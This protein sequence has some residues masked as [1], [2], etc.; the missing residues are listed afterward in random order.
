MPVGAVWGLRCGSAIA[1]RPAAPCFG[2]LGPRE[3]LTPEV[4]RACAVPRIAHLGFSLP[5]AVC[6]CVSLLLREIGAVDAAFALAPHV[7]TIS[8]VALVKVVNL[9][10]LS[11]HRRGVA[12]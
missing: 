8:T 11:A 1:S 7:A 6:G 10:G 12:N 9:D 4:A 2:A 3:R 5:F